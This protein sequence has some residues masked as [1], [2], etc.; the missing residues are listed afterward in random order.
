MRYSANPDVSQII[1][2]QQAYSDMYGIVWD[3]VG[4]NTACRGLREFSL[5][6]VHSFTFE[7]Q[8]IATGV[9]ELL[10]LEWQLRHASF[11]SCT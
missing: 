5:A 4:S 7:Q 8:D 3:F 6:H 10:D 9:D 2:Y 1:I 11:R